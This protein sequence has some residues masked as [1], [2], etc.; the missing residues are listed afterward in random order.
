MCGSYG[1]FAEPDKMAEELDFPTHPA[2]TGYRPSWN[3]AP[4]ASILIV[5]TSDREGVGGM[6]RWWMSP[7]RRGAPAS[8]LLF[9][10]LSETRK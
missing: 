2:R 4:S 5:Y 8:R 7:A 3:T 9:N 1:L 10:A 6:I